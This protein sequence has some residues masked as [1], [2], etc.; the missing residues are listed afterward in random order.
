MN[1]VISKNE[2]SRKA[3]VADAARALRFVDLNPGADTFEAE[4]LEGL[5]ASR[6]RIS[7]KYL[8]DARGSELF[9]RICEL[10]EYYVG[11]TEMSILERHLP[12]I[13]QLLGPRCS[14]LEF[15]SGSSRKTRMLIDALES[16]LRYVPVDISREFL[17]SS[18]TDLSRSYPWLE[19]AAVCADFT[20]AFD[21][22]EDW[23]SDASHRA[24]FF[25]GSTVGNLDVKGVLRFLKLAARIVGPGGTLLLG[26]DRVKDRRVLEAAYDDSQGVTAEFN[27]NLLQRI[28]RELGGNFDLSRFRHRAVFNP[29]HERVEMHL[30][31]QGQQHVTV[32]GVELLFQ[33]GETIH[34]EN[35]YK[36]RPERFEA[37]AYRAGFEPLR[38]WSDD[39]GWFDV[40][41]LQA[42]ARA[43]AEPFD[44][45]DYLIAS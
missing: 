22:P 31:S 27:L 12:E 23:C 44:A 29:M 25:P 3:E 40:W 8:Y 32:G 20:T 35:S 24:A 6:K 43:D 2:N 21:L 42:T 17:L 11:R 37:I 4:I 18:A 45:A 39:R 15:G 14:L 26:V 13:A 7:P 28:N 38:T 30:V 5:L 33:D 36:Y 9:E 34:T 1:P 41:L 10:P 16:P 19:I